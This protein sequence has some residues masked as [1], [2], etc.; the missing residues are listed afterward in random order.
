MLGEHKSAILQ[1]SG[2][3]DSLAAL[4]LARPYLDRITVMFA[5]TGG[6]YPHVLDFVH[7]TCETLGAHLVIVKPDVNV[8][9]YTDRHGLPSD[10]VP[11]WS[12]LEMAQ[13]LKEKPKQLLQPTM[14]CCYQML[15]WP[16]YN[17]V[18]ESGVKLVIRGAK[19][20]DK[21]VGVSPGHID[22]NGIEYTSPIW[23]WTDA[24]VFAYLKGE[25]A[26]LASHYDEV[27]DSLDCW[28]CTGHLPYSDSALKHKYTKDHYPHLWPVVSE[29]LHRMSLSVKEEQ[30]K[31]D[32]VLEGLGCQ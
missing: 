6:T 16:M 26:K 29:R 21:R 32:A 4:Y 19:K 20:A 9:D 28:L 22:Q 13:F 12:T 30:A 7:E 10:M 1:F 25:G 24:D 14:Q 15:L 11:A 31:V 2:G 18:V 17:A 3:K 5:D 27:N 8:M 23:E